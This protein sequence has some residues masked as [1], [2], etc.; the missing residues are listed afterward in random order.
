MSFV[1][2]FVLFMV[3]TLLKVVFVV[4]FSTLAGVLTVA[5]LLL[6][7]LRTRPDEHI[8]QKSK[9]AMLAV[10]HSPLGE[11]GEDSM[12]K[13]EKLA[14][15]ADAEHVEIFRLLL[16]TY[17]SSCERA[18]NAERDWRVAFFIALLVASLSLV[19]NS[20]LIFQAA[21]ISAIV[22]AVIALARPLWLPRLSK[23]LMGKKT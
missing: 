3:F 2:L 23:N 13:F 10:K 18:E 12:A 6:P 22:A 14:S 11:D 1:G 15:K 5:Y 16:Y 7:E 21:G 8:S 19:T 20:S 4:L 9:D 17:R